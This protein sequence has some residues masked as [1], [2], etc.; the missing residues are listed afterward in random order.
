MAG[1]FLK[2]LVKAMRIWSSGAA[3]SSAC[4]AWFSRMV[5]VLSAMVWTLLLGGFSFLEAVLLA[6]RSM[7][8][9]LPAAMDSCN[10]TDAATLPAVFRVVL[11]FWAILLAPAEPP[12]PAGRIAVGLWG[13]ADVFNVPAVDFFFLLP[14]GS[15]SVGAIFVVFSRTRGHARLRERAENC[16]K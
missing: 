15:G 16:K 5:R 4:R 6:E 12:R 8:G 7:L 3:S 10:E 9:P 13:A 11:V 14:P 1:F 2:F